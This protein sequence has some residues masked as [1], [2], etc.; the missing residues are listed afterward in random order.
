MV[1]DDPDVGR[2]A[3]RLVREDIRHHLRLG[4]PKER[5]WE[6]VERLARVAGDGGEAVEGV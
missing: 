4:V 1:V 6:I 3:E 2:E 5:H